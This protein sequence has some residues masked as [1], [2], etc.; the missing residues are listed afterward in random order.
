MAGLI[1][2]GLDLEPII[3]KRIHY[4]QYEEGFEA[5]KRQVPGKVVMTWEGCKSD[6]IKASIYEHRSQRAP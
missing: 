1:K 4:T 3:T 6:K 2:E 5:L